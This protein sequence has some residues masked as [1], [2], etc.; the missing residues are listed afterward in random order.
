MLYGNSK[1]VLKAIQFLCAEE[2][3]TSTLDIKIFLNNKVQDED[4]FGCVHILEND[5]YIQISE[6]NDLYIQVSLTHKG[7]HY[8]EELRAKVLHFLYVSV[9]VPIGV[10]IVTTLITL[11]IASF[12]K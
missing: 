8:A 11:W 3:K 1:K 6:E 5:G 4:L 7:K 9:L 2:N 10:S 12:F